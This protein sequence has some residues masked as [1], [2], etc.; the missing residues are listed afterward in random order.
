MQR[1]NVS[2][3]K[4]GTPRKLYASMFLRNGR[5]PTI[6][7]INQTKEVDLGHLGVDLD[8]L[9]SALQEYVD[10]HLAPVWGTPAKLV[11]ATEPLDNA[12]TMIFVDTAA[13][14]RADLTKTFGK[15]F[16]A[17]LA[18]AHLVNG[19]PVALVFVKNVLQDPSTRLSKRDKVSLAAS[20]ELAEML[21]DPGINLWCDDGNGTLYA[22]EVC[23]MV[24]AKFFRV[25]GLAMSDFVYPAFFEGFHKRK[26]VQFD[27]LKKVKQPFQILKDGYAPVREAGKLHTILRSTTRKKRIELDEEKRDLHRSEF[28]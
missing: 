24:E 5:I 22:Y 21:V 14:F 7:C 3:S 23:D 20:H 12:W 10:G 27:H 16:A 28:R 17:Q 2:S 9:I 1:P 19:R 25:N 26:S 4:R 8:S 13:A 18:S 11:K 15:K 6:A